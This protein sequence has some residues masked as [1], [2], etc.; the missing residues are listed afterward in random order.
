MSKLLGEIKYDL[1]YI[2]NH[3]VQPKWFKIAKIFLLAGFLLGYYFLFGLAA[4]VL[5][6][7]VFFS[8]SFIVHL[9]YRHK[10]NKYS[11][12]WL[13]FV[14]IERDGVQTQRIG[15]FYY[16]A[17]LTNAL[18]ALAISLAFTWI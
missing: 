14:V 5:F 2:K 8:L 1:H 16:L 11:Q 9:I 4:T 3:T 15:K 10:T 18:L 12:S 13:D 17:V 6:C 7:V